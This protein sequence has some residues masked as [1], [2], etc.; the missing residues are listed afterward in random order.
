MSPI[1]D[2]GDDP[3]RV[4]P[5]PPPVIR[6]PAG[7]RPMRCMAC[8][9]TVYLV[10]H[11]SLLPDTRTRI[12]VEVP[13]HDP[14]TLYPP[15]EEADGYGIPHYEFCGAYQRALIATRGHSGRTADELRRMDE[16]ELAA[17]RERDERTERDAQPARMSGGAT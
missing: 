16:A 4:P 10:T 8:G 12:A 15:T 6:I 14:E 1:H 2:R 3:F 11:G 9:V 17:K 5:G 7:K 13:H